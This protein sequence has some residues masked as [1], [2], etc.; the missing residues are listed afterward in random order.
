MNNLQ[1]QYAQRRQERLIGM[2]I[3][4]V[5]Y[6]LQN[7]ISYVD[8]YDSWPDEQTKTSIRLAAE[9]CYI[10]MKKVENELF[11]VSDV[12]YAPVIPTEN[13]HKIPPVKD[14]ENEC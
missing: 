10:H 4:A 8:V 1:E 5:L 6:N 9:A 14:D 11:T 2:A 7:F 12:F 13:R 3:Y